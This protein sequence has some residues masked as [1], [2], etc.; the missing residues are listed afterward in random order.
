MNFQSTLLCNTESSKTPERKMTDGTK[1]VGASMPW[2]WCTS[3]REEVGK[4]VR[5]RE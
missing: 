5:K 1:A 3:E 2:M 4:E